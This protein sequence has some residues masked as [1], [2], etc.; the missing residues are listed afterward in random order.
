[1]T[2]SHVHRSSSDLTT[3]IER[4]GNRLLITNGYSVDSLKVVSGHIKIAMPKELSKTYYV[5]FCMTCDPRAIQGRLD[6]WNSENQKIFSLCPDPDAAND[7]SSRDTRAADALVDDSQITSTDSLD[8]L[9]GS[10]PIND[11]QRRARSRSPSY[12]RLREAPAVRLRSPRL[13]SKLWDDGGNTSGQQASKPNF[14][15]RRSRGDKKHQGELKFCQHVLTELMKPELKHISYPFQ[16]PVDPVAM[17]VPTY[18]TIIKKPMDLG[19]IGTKL[20]AGEYK[21]LQGFEAD[22]RQIFW[23][24]YRFNATTDLVYLMGQELEDIYDGH[25]EKKSEWI[26]KHTSTQSTAV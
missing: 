5:D 19:T 21:G 12:E 22:I 18:S 3:T 23:N 10:H 8:E 15:R 17:N 11:H 25:W 24:C 13:Y 20:K 14:S 26:Q 9:F 4:N 16:N 1:M 6:I 2:D 7:S